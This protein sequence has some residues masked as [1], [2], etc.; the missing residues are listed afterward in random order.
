MRKLLTAGVITATILS[1][2]ASAGT[3]EV[4][5]QKIP[6]YKCSS[7]ATTVALGDVECKAQ[8]CTSPSSPQQMILAKLMGGSGN[9]QAMGKGLGDMLLTALR[10]SNCFKVIDLDRFNKL[11]KKLEATGQ[12]I[13]PPK[14]DKFVNLTITD[15]Q[16]SRS[17][18][19]LGGGF[20]PVLG[21]IKKDTQ[22]A[23]LSVDISVLEPSTLEIE[24]AKTFTADSQETSW[25]LFGAGGAGGVG[26]AGGWSWSK[27]LALD[28]VARDVIVRAVNALAE[29][30]AHD[31]IIE[32][33]VIQPKK[34]KAS[35]QKSAKGGENTNNLLSGGDEDF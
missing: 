23:K 15:I 35:P 34:K 25:G 19:A 2:Q 1:T 14:I 13:T 17:S 4:T 9:I 18:G 20:I 10:E 32:R 22:K 24:F 26:A 30:Y 29:K 7:P 11:K 6:V 8:A 5:E 31:K 3:T 33:P 27:N 21:A 16:L 12:K 28:A